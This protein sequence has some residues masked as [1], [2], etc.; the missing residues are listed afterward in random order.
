[1]ADAI[2]EGI[3]IMSTHPEEKSSYLFMTEGSSDKEYHL[4]LRPVESGW[5]AY[6]ANGSRGRVGT[7]KPIK[8]GV[9]SLEAAT[10]LYEDKLKSKLKSGYTP[11][12]SGVRFTNTEQG[13]KASGH[14]QQLPTAITQQQAEQLIGDDRFVAQEKANGERR[15]IEVVDGV[16]RG[17]NKLGLYV[18]VPENLVS[19][20]TGFGDAVFDGEQVG[21][22]YHAFDLLAYRGQDLRNEP[23]GRRYELLSQEV[24]AGLGASVY[25]AVRLLRAAFTAQEKRELLNLLHSLN[26]EGLVF[27]DVASVYEPGRSKAALKFKFC[28]S[29]TCQV[30]AINQQRSVQ[31][32]L[33]NAAGVHVPVG[34][35]TIPANFAVPAVGELVEV[36]YLYYN[37]EGAFEQPVYLGPR[38]DILPEEANLS[39]VTRLKPGVGMDETGRRTFADD[40]GED[41]QPDMDRP[42]G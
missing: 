3:P 36:Q 12:E 28:E 39:Q 19:A 14:V 41:P 1:M 27:K 37:P 33:L 15:T 38:N 42:V 32:G 29:S 24:L 9:F 34:N 26:G 22:T 20:F 18:N 6:Y 5:C 21:T 13:H 23:F 8:E 40:C 31:L 30:L 17:I 2:E 4:H 25:P 10:K 11:A 16:V 35:V 7:S